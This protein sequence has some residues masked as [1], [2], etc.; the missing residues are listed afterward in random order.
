MDAKLLVYYRSDWDNIDLIMDRITSCVDALRPSHLTVWGP[1]SFEQDQLEIDGVDVTRQD[2]DEIEFDQYDVALVFEAEDASEQQG[3]DIAL[4]NQE[5][6]AKC[7]HYYEAVID[8]NHIQTDVDILNI[9]A[10][11]EEAK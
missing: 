7:I 8:G 6:G 3:D 4:L 10:P 11:G 9:D 5:F 1:A 2:P